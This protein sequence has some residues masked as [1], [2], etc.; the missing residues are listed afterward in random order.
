MFIQ[1]LP[2]TVLPERFQIILNRTDSFEKVSRNATQTNVPIVSGPADSN[3]HFAVLETDQWKN[4]S[5]GSLTGLCI[6]G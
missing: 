3:I 5:S 4:L 6:K 1:G 2:N